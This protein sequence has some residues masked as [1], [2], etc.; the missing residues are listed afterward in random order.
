M[1]MKTIDDFDENDVNDFYDIYFKYILPLKNLSILLPAKYSY[2]LVFLILL[3]I[4]G[5]VLSILIFL[6]ESKN[7]KNIIKEM[8]FS[9]NWQFITDKLTFC[10]D[11]ALSE[12]HKASDKCYNKNNCNKCIELI[13]YWPH[14]INTSLPDFEGI[15]PFHRVCYR[16]NHS[17]IDFMISK[18]AN[19]FQETNSGENA[20]HMLFAYYIR[21]PAQ[22]NFK[23]LDLLLQK[24]Y[25]LTKDNSLKKFIL[26]ARETD[27]K[28]LEK[29]LSSHAI[30]IDKRLN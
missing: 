28:E 7:E 1:L 9:N 8:K 5:V 25:S 23:C 24:G 13:T 18:G 4:I 11:V 26:D 29:W 6:T 3:I 2:L 15:T 12:L 21:N 16:G 30:S 17:L 10:Q 19:I 14:L 27:N 20:F 22:K